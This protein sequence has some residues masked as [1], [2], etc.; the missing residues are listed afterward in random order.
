MYFLLCLFLWNPLRIACFNLTKYDNLLFIKNGWYF[1]QWDH[2]GP[3]G[4]YKRGGCGVCSPKSLGVINFPINEIWLKRKKEAEV[5]G[6]GGA[7]RRNE[8][9]RRC[10]CPIMW[11]SLS[12]RRLQSKILISLPP[13]RMSEPAPRRDTTSQYFMSQSWPRHRARNWAAFPFNATCISRPFNGPRGW[14]WHGVG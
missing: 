13:P 9:E 10:S 11:E 3:R 6:G 4:P 5:G 1:I 14:G 2:R 8:G 12:S 7:E